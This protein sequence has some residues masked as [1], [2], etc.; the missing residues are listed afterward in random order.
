MQPGPH[1]HEAVPDAS[2]PVQR[3]YLSYALLGLVIAGIAPIVLPLLSARSGGPSAPGL[4]MATFNLGMLVA[5]LWGALADRTGWHRPLYVLGLIVVAAATAAFGLHRGLGWLVVMALVIG[6]AASA[7]ATVANLFITERHPRESWGARFGWLQTCYG[8]GQVAGLVLA[9]VFGVTRAPLALALAA[10]AAVLGAAMFRIVPAATHGERP[11]AGRHQP[12]H[13][14]L[15]LGTFMSHVHLPHL[16][17]GL[18]KLPGLM[19]GGPSPFVTFLAG[20]FLGNIGGAAVFSF[21]PLVM[22]HVFGLGA[23][24]ASWA[25]AGAAALGLT[26][27]GPAGGAARRAGP[28]GVYRSGMLLRLAAL[29]FL[30]VVALLHA[31]V[32][33]WLAIGGFGA[34]VLAW[35]LLAVAGSDLAAESSS[36]PQ[37]EAMGLYAATGAVAAV[38]GS[39]LGGLVAVVAGY[40]AL[41]WLAAAFMASAVA[42]TPRRGGGRVTRNGRRREPRGGRAPAGRDGSSP[43]QGDVAAPETGGS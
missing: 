18:R 22:A 30:G 7:T 38:V 43:A 11:V 20:W 9:G 17:R 40:A 25:F 29:L 13:G 42:L 33:G 16:V 4:V 6:L 35:S 37:G 41:V 12:R 39:L 34:V 19:R 27:Y 23:G 32:R 1:V 14:G 3:W 28:A 21:Y 24:A 10:M 36:L 15:V 2:A 5:P 26:L 31:H 8:G